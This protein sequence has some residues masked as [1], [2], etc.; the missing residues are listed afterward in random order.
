M[1]QVVGV[2]FRT[3]KVY[4]FGPGDIAGLQAGDFVIVETARGQ[5]AGKIAFPPREVAEEDIPGSLKSILRVATA[6]DLTQMERY[7]QREKQALYRCREKVEE[8]GLPMKVIRAEYNFDGT[9][10]TFYFAADKRVDFRTLVKSLAHQ[11][12]TRIELRQVG[13][14]DE[15]KLVGG[16]GLCGRP[17]CCSTWLSEFRP[18]SI[19]MAKQ[20]NLPLSPMEISGTCGRLLCCLAYENDHYCEVKSSLPRVGQMVSTPQGEG[21]VIGVNVIKEAVTVQLGGDAT[22]TVTQD[23]LAAERERP[24][25]PRSRKRRR[26]RK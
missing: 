20:Q 14:R 1:P 4:Y 10:L 24:A 7:Q 18:I 8:F 6:V 3:S 15:V 17:H 23:E 11:F 22:V 12:K 2:K 25:K 9:H 26:R 21:K 5:E 19:R 13:V 16:Y